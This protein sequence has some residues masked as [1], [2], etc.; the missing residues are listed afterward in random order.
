MLE[1]DDGIIFS[2]RPAEEKL[3][4]NQYIREAFCLNTTGK[5]TTAYIEFIPE[6]VRDEIRRD[7][8]S[9]LATANFPQTKWPLI[10]SE[11]S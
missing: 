4:E 7:G 10:S 8:R 1:T 6:R 2:I 3:R 5:G 11:K 9:L